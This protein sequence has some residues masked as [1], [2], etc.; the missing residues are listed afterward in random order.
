M[1]DKIPKTNEIDPEDG[2][3]DSVVPMSNVEITLTIK[4]NDVR[5]LTDALDIAALGIIRKGMDAFYVIAKD[6]DSGES[7][8][9]NNGEIYS[10]AQAMTELQKRQMEALNLL[11]HRL[12]EVA[13]SAETSEADNASNAVPAEE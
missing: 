11:E 13:E 8:F 12:D 2:D 6:L 7:W 9:V 1:S 3:F 4:V 5:D 10:A